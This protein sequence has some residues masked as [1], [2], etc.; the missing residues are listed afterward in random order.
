MKKLNNPLT[1][2][3]AMILYNLYILFN[4]PSEYIYTL[5][6]L[7]VLFLLVYLPRA[8]KYY[9]KKNFCNSK[10]IVIDKIITY[11]NVIIYSKE[12]IRTSVS[13]P[14]VDYYVVVEFV[15]DNNT[16]KLIVEDKTLD[17]EVGDSV[18]IYFEKETHNIT[19]IKV[20]DNQFWGEK[21][22][23][24]HLLEKALEQIDDKFP[25]DELYLFH[26]NNDIDLNEL[27]NSNK[28]IK[29]KNAIVE[30]IKE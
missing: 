18:K 14:E 26:K 25:E 4:Y 8:R 2:L 27:I 11:K 1:Y 12:P 23:Q 10:G 6:I 5:I 30:K 20:Y 21:Y 24:I 16:F 7:D 15:H 17:I 28:K 13:M 29:F 9:N 19:Q 22:K 3:I